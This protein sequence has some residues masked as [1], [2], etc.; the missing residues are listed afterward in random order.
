MKKNLKLTNLFPLLYPCYCFINTNVLIKFSTDHAFDKYRVHHELALR[1]RVEQTRT[2]S[3]VSSRPWL[4]TES[5][6]L[7]TEL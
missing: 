3:H 6:S 7:A 5:T 4:V 2:R 1:P